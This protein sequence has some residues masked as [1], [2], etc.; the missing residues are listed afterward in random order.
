MGLRTLKRPLKRSADRL[1]GVVDAV[2]AIQRSLTKAQSI[3]ELVKK[4]REGSNRRRGPIG[5]LEKFLQE[6]PQHDNW[7]THDFGRD[8]RHL[9][10]EYG[11]ISIPVDLYEVLTPYH[12]ELATSGLLSVDKELRIWI[13]DPLTRCLVDGAPPNYPA[14]LRKIRSLHVLAM[15]L[16][17]NFKA[18]IHGE[19]VSL[20]PLRTAVRKS[21][22]NEPVTAPRPQKMVQPPMRRE[23]VLVIG[24]IAP[25]RLRHLKMAR[26]TETSSK[27][28]VSEERQKWT[29][30]QEDSSQNRKSNDCKT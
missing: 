27:E 18:A 21:H 3:L 4:K 1:L 5:E 17:A 29:V 16:C 14:I 8:I 6:W 23:Q 9:K 10:N 13:V 26:E 19:A 12:I 28:A 25:T 24:K 7:I 20:R 11:T 15:E 22:R 30:F 2:N